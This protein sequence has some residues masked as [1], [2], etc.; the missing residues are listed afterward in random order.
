[1]KRIL[2]LFAIVFTLISCGGVSTENNADRSDTGQ[3]DLNNPSAIDTT[4]HPD[5]MI[6]GSVISTDTAAMNMQNAVDKAKA[7]KKQ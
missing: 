6:N 7:G 4:K 5:G 3:A 1:M 2:G